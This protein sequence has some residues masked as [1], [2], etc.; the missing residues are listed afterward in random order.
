MIN[1]HLSY[2]NHVNIVCSK[3]SSEIGIL[4]RIR[5]FIPLSLGKDLYTSLIMP[6]F[7]YS[8]ILLTEINARLQRRVQFQQN[9]ALWVV[10]NVGISYSLPKLFTEL[11]VDSVDVMPKKAACKLV[12]WA[13]NNICPESINNLF[14]VHV[15]VDV[16][17][18]NTEFGDK[19]FTVCGR[20]L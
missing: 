15:R 14:N 2:E 4:S 8:N 5:S 17:K 20:K 19:N 16:P 6:H 18:M 9:S 11:N 1:S 10:K 13:I 7:I 12:Y 3:I